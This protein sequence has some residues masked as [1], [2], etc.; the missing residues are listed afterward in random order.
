MRASSSASAR[1][2][3]CVPSTRARASRT[4]RATTTTR[5]SVREPDADSVDVRTDANA[6]DARET[7]PRAVS[8]REDVSLGPVG[9]RETVDLGARASYDDGWVALAERVRDARRDAE[10]AAAATFES[11]CVRFIIDVPR[12]ARAS[13]GGGGERTR[14]ARDAGV[15]LVASGQD[16]EREHRREEGIEQTRER[17]FG[18]VDGVDDE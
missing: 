15:L 13:V 2:H 14:R 16:G 18:R 1:A 12:D 4:R 3:A 8:T 9:A 17:W 10:R 11:G 6:R 7:T 5:Q